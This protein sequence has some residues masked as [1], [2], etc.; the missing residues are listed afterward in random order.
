MTFAR[1]PHPDSTLPG[2]MVQPR[3]PVK[4]SSGH[5]EDLPKEKKR[6][7][8][9]LMWLLFLAL[10]L[11]GTLLFRQMHV[12]PTTPVPD[13]GQ[14]AMTPSGAKGASSAAV[15]FDPKTLDPET[16][17]RLSLDL[18]ALPPA[19]AVTLQ[20]D[21]K[22]YWTGVAGDHDS[23]QGLMVP[24]GQHTFRA[25]VMAAGARKSS[26]NVSGDF[27]AKKRMTL[28]IKLWPESNGVV[29]DPSSDVIETLERSIFPL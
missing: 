13:A 27:A 8:S 3:V 23:Y 29:F 21:G 6:G 12:Q 16:N 14:S 1:S 24:P 19:L 26:A 10:A 2:R 7:M 11:G 22:T 20:M 4:A 18:D 25:V 9:G 17:A 15:D 28:T 5:S